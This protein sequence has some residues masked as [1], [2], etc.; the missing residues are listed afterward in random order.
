MSDFEAPLTML[1]LI[2]ELLDGR[3]SDEGLSNLESFLRGNPS[4]QRIFLNYCQL[5]ID[6]AIDFR[7]DKALR[8]FYDRKRRITPAATPLPTSEGGGAF[9]RQVVAY[10]PRWLSVRTLGWG[11]CAVLLLAVG[12]WVWWSTAGKQ[13]ANGPN[14]G[15]GGPA[16]KSPAISSIEL[17]KGATT[18][19]LDKIGSVVVEGPADFKLT[20]PMRCRL[21]RGRIRVHI[22]QP[23]AHGFV[24]ETPDGEVTDLGTEFG[25]EVAERQNSG[26]N[27]GLVVFKGAVDLRIADDRLAMGTDRVRRLEQGDGVLFERGGATSRVVSV[28]ASDVPT[29]R[30]GSELPASGLCS[31]IVGISDNLR[32]AN[33]TKFYEI[34]PGGLHEGVLAYVDRD[35]YEWIGAGESGLPPYLNG[36]DY[37]KPFN[38]DK[39]SNNINIVVSLGR[40]SRLFVFFDDRVAPPQWLK[41]DFRQTGDKIAMDQYNEESPATHISTFSIWERTV[42]KPGPITFGPCQLSSERGS[43]MYS[44]AAVPLENSETPRLQQ[45]AAK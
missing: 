4:A 10:R 20:G 28:I 7:A 30:Q 9:M 34:V 26:L 37:I 18:L 6:L 11:L 5:H 29:F 12:N 22:S 45:E 25:L 39:L 27:S 2:D 21:N 8:S 24:V 36:A 16:P 35:T 43:N 38:D 40:P 32:A 17:A 15:A 44:I 1:G 41:D 33:A 23:G 42:A 31:L 3:I 14:V 13:V 19:T